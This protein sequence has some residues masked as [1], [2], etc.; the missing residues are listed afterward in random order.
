[1]LESASDLLALSQKAEVEDL[2]VARAAVEMIVARGFH[3]GRD[4]VALL[5]QA[6]TRYRE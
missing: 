2:A 4:L 1:M 3:R 5:E 6:L